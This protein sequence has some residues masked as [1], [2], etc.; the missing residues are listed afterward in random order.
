MFK[1]LGLVLL[2]YTLY[3]TT[4]GC[5]LARSGPG[6]KMIYRSECPR[7]FWVVIGVYLAL[8]AALL[9]AFERL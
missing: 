7:Y 9:T 1:L 6:M 3:A 4:T 8:G 2:L 5:V